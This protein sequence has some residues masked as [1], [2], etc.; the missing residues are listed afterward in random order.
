MRLLL[1][2]MLG[3]VLA[4]Y[5]SCDGFGRHGGVHHAYYYES[6]VPHTQAT[7]S[8]CYDLFGYHVCVWRAQ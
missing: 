4:G 6:P 8:G 1:G 7:D 2:L 5:V 3:L